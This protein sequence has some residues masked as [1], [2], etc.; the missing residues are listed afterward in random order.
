MLNQTMPWLLGYISALTIGLFIGYATLYHLSVFK[1]QM[2][3]AEHPERL[4]RFDA[5]FGWQLFQNLNRI[6]PALTERC[7]VPMPRITFMKEGSGIGSFHD[8][9]SVHYSIVVT[10]ECVEYST[11]D[12]EIV[13]MRQIA[14]YRRRYRWRPLL[15]HWLFIMSGY[16]LLWKPVQEDI[17]IDCYVA[18]FGRKEHILALLRNALA[19]TR[20]TE[21]PSLHRQLR[22]RI[23]AVTALPDDTGSQ[24]TETR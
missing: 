19:S 6:L 22:K 5:A 23:A 10:P 7:K 3:K 16:R 20:V 13:L 15:Q 1:P 11:E 8:I 9:F 24:A 17:A 12:L 4:L 2:R 18:R 14:F 21:E